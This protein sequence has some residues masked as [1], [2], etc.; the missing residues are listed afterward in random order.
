MARSHG[1]HVFARRVAVVNVDDGLG[2]QCVYF[3]R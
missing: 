3:Y 1:E 2:R